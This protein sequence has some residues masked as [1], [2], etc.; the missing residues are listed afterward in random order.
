M[1]R[2]TAG[3]FAAAPETRNGLARKVN[4]TA[5]L[6]DAQTS[7]RIMDRESSPS[8]IEGPR[9]NCILR[10]GLI[11]ILV[12]ACLHKGVVASNTFGEHLAVHLPLLP[13]RRID[14]GGQGFKCIRFKEKLRITD[15]RRQRNVFA[16]K[17][18]CVE[19]RPLRTRGEIGFSGTFIEG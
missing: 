5:V 4:H 3:G 6:I 19:D 7:V 8:C 12:F 9:F 1:L 14:L 11:E 17:R 15:S 18:F 10:R 13:R 16:F 2:R